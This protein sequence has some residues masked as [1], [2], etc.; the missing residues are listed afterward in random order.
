[1]SI[2]QKLLNAISAH[3]K[4]VTFDIGLVITLA[5]GTAIGMLDNHNLAFAGLNSQS[6]PVVIRGP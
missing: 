4:L 1:M 5:V 3:P 6:K 2:K